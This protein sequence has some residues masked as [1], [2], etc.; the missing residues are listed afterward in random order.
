[1]AILP[2]ATCSPRGAFT[3]HLRMPCVMEPARIKEGIARL[4]KAWKLWAPPP[5]R[6][7][8]AFEVV[9]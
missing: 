9:V 2:G 3:D 8:A 5:A 1:V 7:A 4:A 6:R